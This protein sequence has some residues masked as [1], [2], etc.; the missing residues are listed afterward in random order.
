VANI[1]CDNS[2]KVFK[3]RFGANLFSEGADCKAL[4]EDYFGIKL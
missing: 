4:L 1:F 2:I 3:E